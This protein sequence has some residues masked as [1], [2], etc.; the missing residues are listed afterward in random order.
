MSRQTNYTYVVMFSSKI[1]MQLFLLK[2]YLI[3]LSVSLNS[4]TLFK[5]THFDYYAIGDFI[6]ADEVLVFL[7]G[8]LKNPLIKDGKNRS[9]NDLIEGNQFFISQIKSRNMMVIAPIV[10]TKFNWVENYDYVSSCLLEFLAE[11]KKD[12]TIYIAGF[13]D[14]GTGAYRIF[15]QN[16]SDFDGLMIFN[17][18]PQ[19]N[20]YNQKIDYSKVI[21]KPIIFVSSFKDEMIPYEFLLTEYCKQKKYNPNTFLYI[22]EGKHSFSVYKEKDLSIL[23]NLLHNENEQTSSFNIPIHG[24]VRS[25]TIFSFYKFRKKIVRR[26]DYGAD[27]FME[28]KIQEKRLKNELYRN[29]VLPTNF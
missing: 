5:T 12:R 25:D 19:L 1:L 2:L 29:G 17:G 28:N 7:H 21:S 9:F 4:Q 3:L 16:T 18:Y 26:Y 23:F 27:F 11:E 22:T 20:N 8:G 14:G 10:N 15:Y 13:S 24:L 6:E